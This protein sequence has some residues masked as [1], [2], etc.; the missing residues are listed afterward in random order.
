MSKVL[1][2][3]GSG[4]LPSLTKANLRDHIKSISTA[5]EIDTT[6]IR[7]IK[8]SRYAISG[9]QNNK[10]FF[11]PRHATIP[12]L[13]VYMMIAVM[14]KRDRASVGVMPFSIYTKLRIRE[15][16]PTTLIVELADRTVKCPKGIAENVLV[17][18][19][20][21][22]PNDMDLYRDEGMGDIIVGRL[23]CKEARVK[24]SQFDGMITICKGN[25]SVTYQMARS[26][27]MFKH[28]TYAQCNK[29][30]P[31]LKV[32]I[33]RILVLKREWKGEHM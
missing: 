6:P 14:K 11:K 21:F 17:R 22:F 1:Q 9:S 8:P 2:E 4:N 27:Q 19:D 20:N 12:F 32:S 16:A 33:W 5:V 3:R 31:L 30:R 29:M 13:V 26:H 18:I 10:M 15:L 23:F 24:A 28:L 7:R 25:D